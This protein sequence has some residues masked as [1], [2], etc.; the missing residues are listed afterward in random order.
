MPPSTPQRVDHRAFLVAGAVIA[1][2]TLTIYARVGNFEFNNFDD[3]DYVAQN[4][5]VQHGIT[6]EGIRWA[7]STNDLSA[8]SATGTQD[9][10]GNWHPLTWLSHML[11]CQ[12][13][14]VNPGAHHWVNVVIHVCNSLL[15]LWV[16][17]R[18]TNALA[19]SAIVAALFAVHPLHV[20]SVAWVAERKDVL[21][22]LFW[23][24]TMW[25]YLRY[26]ETRSGVPYA[27][28]LLFFALGLMSKPMLITLP[29]VL[30]LLDYWPLRRVAIRWDWL[31]L[32][33]EK[34]PLFALT[35]LSSVLTF[36][37]QKQGGAVGSFEKF[38]LEARVANAM[39]AYVTYLAKTILPEDL[40]VFYP[41]SG[42]WPVWQIMGGALLL[43]LLTA[44]ALALRRPAT[45]LVV[46]WFWYLG[47]LVPVIG[48]VQVGD[49]A[50]ADRYTYVPL[51]GIFIAAAWGIGD[52]AGR[53]KWPRFAV[54]V[55]TAVILAV[56]A[57]ITM[58]QVEHWRNSETLFRH[59]VAVTKDNHLAHY[60]LGQTL[61]VNGR[62]QEAIEHYYATLRLKPDHEG[63]H[64]NLGL[65]YALQGEWTQATNH[66]THALRSNPRNPDVHF[67]M[68]IA[69]LHLGHPGH[70][71]SHFTVTLHGRPSHPLAHRYVADALS[72]CGR[73][74][75]AI[76][77]YRTALKLNPNQ[78]EALNHLAWILA[79][80]PDEKLRDGKEAVQ[81]AERACKLTHFAAPLMLG[82]LAAA[83]AET[84]QF[85]NAVETARRAEGL[86]ARQGDEGLAAKNRALR[87]QYE[88]GQPHRQ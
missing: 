78:P 9:R 34:V 10:M 41:H 45:Y 23:F 26:V 4:A 17:Y 71:V 72:A 40:A 32:T 6:L 21:S 76:G 58:S 50:Y 31:R 56:Y 51:T 59:A 69:Q 57:A 8:L 2:L 68:G 88:R 13:F 19:R 29:F 1:L 16:L 66:Y 5:T 12:L 3:P 81:L 24:L 55:A 28:A 74:R 85:T 22:T 80:H 63:A 39:V 49:Q 67:N 54:P 47:T 65:T 61:S 48:L 15:L 86:A 84:G 38:S 35:I 82:T 18:Y 33:R 27:F 20:E 73:A 44:G 46:G 52:L 42:S 87:E 70:A 36:L 83:Q 14:G 64:N 60:N 77:H 75:D 79:T 30:L 43:L 25:A 11:D 7:F 62:I 37:V 53:L